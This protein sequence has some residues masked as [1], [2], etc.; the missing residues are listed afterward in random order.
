MVDSPLKGHLAWEGG[1]LRE[2]FDVSVASAL[3]KGDQVIVDLDLD[4]IIPETPPPVKIPLGKTLA[5]TPPDSRGLLGSSSAD[6]RTFLAPVIPP[7]KNK[8]KQSAGTESPGAKMARLLSR[9][10][11]LIKSL[12]VVCGEL[13]TVDAGERNPTLA[14]VAIEAN[15]GCEEATAI[16]AEAMAV[17][18]IERWKSR[19]E[20]DN[21]QHMEVASRGG[22][23]KKAVRSLGT[24]TEERTFNFGT[25]PTSSQVKK[26]GNVNQ[27][28]VR[29]SPQEDS[30]GP[31]KKL[32]AEVASTVPAKAFEPKA[33]TPLNGGGE[34]PAREEG[35]PPPIREG[36]RQNEQEWQPTRG[37][38]RRERRA[39]HQQEVQ[40]QKQ[41]NHL[42]QQQQPRLPRQQQQEQEQRGQSPLPRQRQEKRK[43]RPPR[44]RPEAVLVR[45]APTSSYIDTYRL[46][47][48]KGRDILEGVVGAKRTR[49]GHVLLELG[50]Q[51]SAVTLVSSLRDKLGGNGIDCSPLQDRTAVEVRG[52]DPMVEGPEVLRALGGG[53]L[54]S[55]LRILNLKCL[56]W[57]RWVPKRR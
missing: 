33:P 34:R 1:S 48:S 2:F 40:R 31:R 51:N 52:I 4:T 19:A 44:K 9:M 47:L 54:K 36:S 24:Q 43:P 12:S 5:R 21:P 27:K 11:D 28:R 57:D 25:K 23:K 30:A 39:K 50:K 17:Q 26:R 53:Y 35:M 6:G 20:T 16:V 8:A 29:S 56:R 45:V 7:P 46:L 18:S 55:T 14:R 10:A 22:Q 49:L 37:Q 38:L 13:A 15:K 3:W 42:Q 32:F 41:Q